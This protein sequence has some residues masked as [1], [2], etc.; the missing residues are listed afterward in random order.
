MDGGTES[1]RAAEHLLEED[2]RLDAA[3]EDE[4]RDCGDVDARREQVDRHD[5]ARIRFVLEVLHGLAYLLL[6][7]IL[8]GAR[9]L[10]DGVGRC[11]A[12]IELP[13][14]AHDEV[15][16]L[17]VR[18][19]DHHLPLRGLRRVEIL[20][21]LL[22]HFPV[23]VL[24]DDLAIEVVDVEVELILELRA[25]EE[26]ARLRVDHRD[27]LPFLVV[28]ALRRELRLD[29][30]GRI[31][32]DEVAVDDGLAVGIREDGRAEDLRRVQCRRGRQRDLH[33]VEVLDDIAV[34]A[35]IVALV[36]VEGRVLAHIAVE[37]VAAVR[38][39]DDDEVEVRDGWHRLAFLIED[40]AH[41]ALD[42]RDL[43]A[44]LT[45]DGG[46]VGDA[47]DVVDLCE[48]LELGE[49]DLAKGVLCL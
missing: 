12:F 33:G 46:I 7:A 22:E 14:Q 36:A 28:D 40:A 4:R 42:R 10:A 13:E 38:F 43:H 2:A 26:F 18:G 35:Q 21:N 9:D 11:H 31:V 30:D 27:L 1:R 5:D 3:Q 39:V 17:V 37:D 6:V 20:G 25:I 8:D 41:E 15:G 29:V 44:R 19:E 48:C 23:E 24:G 16:V 49:L 45:L 34:L 47:L 32:V